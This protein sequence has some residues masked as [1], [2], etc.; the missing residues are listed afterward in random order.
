MK[1]MAIWPDFEALGDFTI[2]A[3]LAISQF[4]LE[5]GELDDAIDVNHD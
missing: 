3:A 4:R 2:H 5:F 1:T